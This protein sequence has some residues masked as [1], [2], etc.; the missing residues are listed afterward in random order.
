MTLIAGV[1]L[2]KGVL[3]VSDT[4]ETIDRTEE[5]FSESKRKI[6]TVTR[7]FFIGGSGHS[8]T[9]LAANILRDTLYNKEVNDGLTTDYLR[10]ATLK[11]FST[12]NEIHQPNNLYGEPVGNI[13]V[14]EYDEDNDE[15]NLLY[16][17]GGEG[18]DK[19]NVLNKTKDV[20]L[21]GATHEIQRQVTSDINILLNSAA[22][23]DEV[24]NHQGLY[25]TLSIEIQ[26]YFQMATKNYV[27]VG[28]RVYCTYL[29]EI[30][31]KPAYHVYILDEDGK[32]IGV[33]FNDGSEYFK[34]LSDTSK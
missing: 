24:L 10:N 2:P 30:N 3:L 4:R 6:V 5:I 32:E 22:V 19:F 20:M 17:F 16:I 33:D 21:I 25:Y 8:G 1:K 14:A 29:T 34:E 31:K 7:K 11:L 15:F 23:T 18:F 27:G 9:D 28:D 12:V 26:K 13:L